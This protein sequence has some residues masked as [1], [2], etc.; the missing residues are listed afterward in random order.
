MEN[1]NCSNIYD[2]LLYIKETKD[3]IRAAI[4]ANDVEVLDSD[5]FR[6]YA[7]YIADIQKVKSVNEK[8]G[9]VIV[10][11]KV[12]TMEEYNN[13]ENKDKFTTYLITD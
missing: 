9:D 5:T 3:L 7:E 11:D 12:L 13:L 2:K 1:Y 10:E 6:K 8:I 4:E